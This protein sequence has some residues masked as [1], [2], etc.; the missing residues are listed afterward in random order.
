MSQLSVED[1][2][3]LLSKLE[4]LT[5]DPPSELLK[6]DALRRKL[7]EAAKNASIALEIPGDTMHRITNAVREGVYTSVIGN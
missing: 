1:A 2:E 3:T 4:S 7:R 5:N 6:N